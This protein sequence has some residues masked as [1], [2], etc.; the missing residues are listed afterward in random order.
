MY[1][2][3]ECFWLQWKPPSAL[4]RIMCR[5]RKS[6]RTQDSRI[7]RVCS[8]HHSEFKKKHFDEI[9]NVKWLEISS[10]SWMRSALSHDQ[11]TKW[12]K[13]Q[14]CV[15][16][17][18]VQCVGQMKDTPESV[19]RWERTSGRTQVV[20][21]LLWCSGYRWRSNWIR[22][23]KFP[24][25][26]IIVCSWRNPTRRSG[27]SSQRSSQTGSFMSMFNDIVWNTNDGNCLSNAE[28]VKNYAMRFSK[29]H[30]TFLGPGSEEKWYGSSSDAQK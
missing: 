14:V 29:G 2:Y 15:Y 6:A 9:Q 3:G 28:K 16:A 30:W 17:D 21:V 26:F 8:N 5:I 12:A 25:I 19:E 13:A 1:W 18:S 24:R 7:L 23:D 20:F 11:A 10:P 4:G 22:V 27:R